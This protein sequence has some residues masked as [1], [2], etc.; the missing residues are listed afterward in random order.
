MPI[1]AKQANNATVQTKRYR[2][3]DGFG[4][5]LEIR[6]S[7]RKYWI[8]RYRNPQT[9]KPTVYTIGEYP[10]ITLHHARTALLEI[11][12]LIR[13]RI[14]PNTH[15]KHQYKQNN[16]KCFQSLA[17]EWHRNQLNRW[18]WNNAK[19]V[20]VSFEKDVFPF[21]GD[22]P[23]TALETLELLQVIRKI[24]ARG[25][26]AQAAKV[27][28]RIS[29][30]LNYAMD[31]G[32]IKFNP[33]PTTGAMKARGKTQHFKAITPTDLPAFLNDLARYRQ[34]V[35][36]RAVQFALLTFA[37]TGSIIA[38]EW[39]EIDWEKAQWIIPAE[40]MK[41]GQ[42]HLIPLSTQ[43]LQLLKELR[44]F[45]GD[46][47]LIFYAR[48]RNKMLSANAMRNVLKKIGWGAKTTI[49]GFRALASSV[50]HDAGY[51]LHIIEKQLA[52]AERNKTAGAYN[53]MAQYLEDRAKMLQWWADYLQQHAMDNAT[54]RS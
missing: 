24:E 23:I 26:L 18:T 17:R 28:Q 44:T 52:H 13:Q 20:M 16:G 19:Q 45:T 10:Y 43:A 8:H 15:R 54:V 4:L 53:Y 14:D 34:E 1:T 7:G 40:H 25:S 50:L 2:L 38:A 46:S 48:Y 33:I 11:K 31:T 9:K 3:N 36:R 41:M 37:R 42:A 30:V 49:H 6:P 22:R 27:R 32:Q 35:M 51:P 21:I 29:A 5:Q 39:K 47:H 12:G